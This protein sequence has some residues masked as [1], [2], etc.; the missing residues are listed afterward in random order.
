MRDSFLLD[1]VWPFIS[2]I[3][4]STYAKIL[5]QGS[6]AIPVH[7]CISSSTVFNIDGNNQSFLSSKSSY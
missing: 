5:I 7:W 6:S 1:N 2:W 4:T 3:N